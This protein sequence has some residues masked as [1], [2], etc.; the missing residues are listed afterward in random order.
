MLVALVEGAEAKFSSSGPRND[1]RSPVAWVSVAVVVEG[2]GANISSSGPK[3]ESRPEP[4]PGHLQIS[5][6]DNT[7]TAIKANASEEI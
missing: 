3:N 6:H 1:S 4:R 7:S 5:I 2:A